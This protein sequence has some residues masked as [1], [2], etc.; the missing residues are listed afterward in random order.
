MS[1]D[2]KTIND[3]A[4]LAKLTITECDIPKCAQE[5]NTILTLVGT[6]QDIETQHITPMAHPMDVTQRLRPDL[7]TENNVREICQAHAPA[8]QDG[9]YLVPKVID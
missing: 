2:F 6:L 7:V 4:T 8:V 9:F 1:L 5:I 3:I